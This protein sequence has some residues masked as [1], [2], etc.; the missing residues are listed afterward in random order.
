MS[1]Y[2]V[3]MKSLFCIIGLSV[4]LFTAAAADVIRSGSLQANS[5][6]V[7]VTLRW[8][9][10]DEATVAHFEVERRSGT[11]GAFISLATVDPKGS[12]LYEYIDNSA[13][14]KIVTLYQYR[15]KIVYTNGTNPTY[16]GIL[17]VSHTVSGVRRTWGSIKS[18]FR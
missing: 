4:F 10:D 12:S 7:N 6:G 15:V 17:T 8:I 11:D 13:F 2:V 18:M 9:T 1:N 16:T 5:D 14:R 3:N